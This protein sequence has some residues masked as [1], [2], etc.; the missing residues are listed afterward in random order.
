MH[1]PLTLQSVQCYSRVI[2][3]DRLAA[4]CEA[5]EDQVSRRSCKGRL[6]GGALARLCCT[7]V[8]QRIEP[9]VVYGLLCASEFQSVLAARAGRC[10]LVC[11]LHIGREAHWHA[12]LAHKQNALHSPAVQAGTNVRHFPPGLSLSAALLLPTCRFSSRSN[13]RQGPT[14]LLWAAGAASRAGTVAAAPRAVHLGALLEPSAVLLAAA[15]AAAAAALPPAAA[16]GGSAAVR[17]VRSARLGREE[18]RSFLAFLRQTRRLRTSAGTQQTWRQALMR[19]PPARWEMGTVPG[20][21]RGVA[22]CASCLGCSGGSKT[23]VFCC[24]LVPSSALHGRMASRSTFTSHSFTAVLMSPACILINNP[25][26]KP[27]S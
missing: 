16:L 8:Q 18:S 20:W 3:Q 1:P 14:S 25:C 15:A 27:P 26:P 11:C 5:E 13:R 23:D 2:H 24:Q 22:L 19:W 21:R 6:T 10:C 4:I 7:S 17:S 9:G 12:Y